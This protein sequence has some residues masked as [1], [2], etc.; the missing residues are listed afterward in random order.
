[1]SSAAHLFRISNNCCYFQYADVVEKI[2]TNIQNKTR[3]S[4]WAAEH[5]KSFIICLDFLNTQPHK[6]ELLQLNR[7]QIPSLGI[8][9]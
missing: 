1:M 2:K 9:S 6:A 7:T 8:L 3:S 5:I 4:P